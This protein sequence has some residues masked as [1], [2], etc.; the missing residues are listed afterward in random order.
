MKSDHLPESRGSSFAC[1]ICQST[2]VTRPE[3]YEFS[4][5]ESFVEHL[6]VHLVKVRMRSQPRSLRSRSCLGQVY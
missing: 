1:T 3:K 4:R 6:L 5:A 2:D